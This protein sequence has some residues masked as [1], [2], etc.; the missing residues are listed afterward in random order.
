MEV[1]ELIKIFKEYSKLMDECN[2]DKEIDS[3]INK[4]VLKY[5]EDKMDELSEFIFTKY[6][7][8]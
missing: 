7:S 6:A 5:G 8:Y 4:F 2:S 3:I 1:N